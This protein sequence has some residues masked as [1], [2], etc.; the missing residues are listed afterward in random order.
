[1]SLAMKPTLR[2]AMTASQHTSRRMLVAGLAPFSGRC[3]LSRAAR[4]PQRGLRLQAQLQSQQPPVLD[5][6]RWD[7]QVMEGKVRFGT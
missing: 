3:G 2:P 5:E 1:M 6:Q 7:A 4:A